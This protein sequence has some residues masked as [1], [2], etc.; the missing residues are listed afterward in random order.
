MIQNLPPARLRHCIERIRRRRGSCH[1][2]EYIFPYRNMSRSFFGAGNACPWIRGCADEESLY[3][4]GV[5][6]RRRDV[7][8][9]A[10]LEKSPAL[11]VGHQ[12]PPK[13]Q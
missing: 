7:A 1:A 8:I 11:D 2:Q 9:V 10:G 4:F 13:R 12:S 3:C 6:R 5:Q